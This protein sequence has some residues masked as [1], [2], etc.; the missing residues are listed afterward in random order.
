MQV[1]TFV[2][3]TLKRLEHTH[4]SLD[5]SQ[6]ITQKG[7]LSHFYTLCGM[8]VTHGLPLFRG[9][10][11]ACF[12]R[13]SHSEVFCTELY[14]RDRTPCLH[15]PNGDNFCPYSDDFQTNI[16]RIRMIFVQIFKQN[17]DESLEKIFTREFTKSPSSDS[18]L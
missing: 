6:F 11:K 7:Y 10:S 17:L 3:R 12:R 18:P 16:S 5:K 13:P 1:R 4:K 14:L 15:Y 8:G 9:A 2:A